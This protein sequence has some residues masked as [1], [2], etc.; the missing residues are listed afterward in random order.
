MVRFDLLKEADVAG[1]LTLVGEVT[2]LSAD[3]RVRRTHVIRRLLRMIG[4]RSVAFV[5]IANPDEGPFARAGTIINLNTSGEAEARLAEAFMLHYTVPDPAMTGFLVTRGQRVTMFRQIDDRDWYRSDHF[6]LLR[7][8]FDMDHSL[9]A[10]LP[11]PGGQDVGVAIQ[12]SLR[13]P[14]FTERERA[15]VHFLHTHAS[16]VYH[17]QP[18]SAPEIEALAPRLKPVLRLL[19]Q[20]DAEKQVAA[21]LKLSRHTIHRYSQTIYRGLGVNTRAELL[22]RYARCA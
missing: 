18:P 10:R 12:R 4:G 1:L 19:L 15:M 13:E 5:E 7:R 8:P 16:Q 14:V 9:Y 6:N 17:V 2:E 21:K 20:G 22:A 11:L 3:K